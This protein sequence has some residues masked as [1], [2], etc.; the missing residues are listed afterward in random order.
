[1]WIYGNFILMVVKA[2]DGKPGT[3]ALAR[4]GLAK[5]LSRSR[6]GAGPLVERSPY[7]AVAINNDSTSAKSVLN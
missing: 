6:P 3:V 7:R 1:M 5:G 4:V 2:N